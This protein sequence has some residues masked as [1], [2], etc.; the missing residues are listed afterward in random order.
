MSL[1]DTGLRS[2]YVSQK[3]NHLLKLV[4]SDNPVQFDDWDP[5]MFPSLDYLDVSYNYYLDWLFW[6]KLS[7][8]TSLRFF[9]AEGAAITEIPSSIAELPHLIE[10]SLLGNRIH[11]LPDEFYLLRLRLV[12]LEFNPLERTHQVRLEEV[13]G[14]RILY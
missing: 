5:A 9:V 7:A 6:E 2:L 13:F 3:Q 14:N 12:N 8:L 4:I 10:I 11:E 1:Y